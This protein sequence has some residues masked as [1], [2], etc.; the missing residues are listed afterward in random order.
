VP[1]ATLDANR[2][3]GERSI[4][5]DQVTMGAIGRSGSDSL[6][7]SYKVCVTA[8]GTVSAVTQLKSSGFPGYDE[9]IQSTI[10]R[11]WRYRPFVRNGKAT[12]VCTAFRFVYS[13]S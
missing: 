13:Q 2:I 9:K 7:S 5:P 12:A 11:D 3:A 10:R 8:Q 1:A 4:A 6:V